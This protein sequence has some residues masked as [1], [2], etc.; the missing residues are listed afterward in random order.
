MLEPMRSSAPAALAGLA[1]AAYL[2]CASPASAAAQ[3]CRG[4]M[5]TGSFKAI[6]GSAGAGN[7]VYRLRLRNTSHITCFVSGIPK[8]QLLDRAGKKLPTH[9]IFDGPPG[10]LTAIVVP[11]AHGAAATLTARFSPD[12]PGPGE[13]GRICEKTSV[14]LRVALP[15]GAVT[16]PISPPTPVCEHGQLQLRVFTAA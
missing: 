4:P 10:A 16:V 7:I 3:P 14:K 12:V 6:P 11:L 9:T 15:G 13:T 2:V 1:A 8:L 5:L